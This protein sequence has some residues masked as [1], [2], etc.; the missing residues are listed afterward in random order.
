MI[1]ELPEDDPLVLALVEDALAHHAAQLSPE[2]REDAREMLLL[3]ITTHPEM[4][5][6]VDGLRDR[7]HVDTSGEVD[8]TGLGEVVPFPARASGGSR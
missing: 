1:Q 3:Y 6:L 4:V 5:A 8:R 7:P 2:A